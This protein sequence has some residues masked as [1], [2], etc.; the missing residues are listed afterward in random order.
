M[1][2]RRTGSIINL[3]SS[4]QARPLPNLAHY[5]SSKAAVALFTKCAA[6]ELAPFGIRVNAI[7]PGLTETDINRQDVADPEFR[8]MRLRGIPLAKIAS[9][10]DIA[11][12]AIYL[13]SDESAMATGSIIYVDG[14]ATI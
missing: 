1:V 7:A 6:L 9:P 14:G 4:I 13:A 8:D 5:A 2:E 11:G 3:T 12:A 10:E